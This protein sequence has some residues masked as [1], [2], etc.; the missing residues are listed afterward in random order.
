VS[1]LWFRNNGTEKPFATDIFSLVNP[2]SFDK[3]FFF[4]FWFSTSR[5]ILEIYVKLKA[6]L[7]HVTRLPYCIHPKVHC[8]VCA[9]QS[10][11][12]LRWWTI[13]WYR[14][15]GQ[16]EPATILVFIPV[17]SLHSIY[18]KRVWMFTLYNLINIW[19]EVMLLLRILD[20]VSIFIRSIIDWLDCM[21]RS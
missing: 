12:D 3:S 19:E 5:A 18:C 9:M 11:T 10:G 14:V 1:L 6:A 16:G 13:G 20:K 8:M 7:F 2:I 15:N 17:I 4:P 21:P